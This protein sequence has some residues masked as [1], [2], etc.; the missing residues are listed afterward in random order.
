MNVETVNY[1]NISF[2]SWDVGGRSNVR[3]LW[4]H[5]FQNVNAMIY[6]LDSNDR[7]RISEAENEM[8]RIIQMFDDQSLQSIPILVYC[9]KQDLPNAMSV[10]EC[11]DKLGLH[12]LTVGHPWYIQAACF[13]SGDG[14]Y[15]GLE[16]LSN[17]LNNTSRSPALKEIEKQTQAKAQEKNNNATTIAVTT[18]AAPQQQISVATSETVVTA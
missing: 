3:P 9:N 5:Y 11:T 1:K 14:I 7:E 4:R 8:S 15:E 10:A 2:T 17:A 13:T 12:K 6:V 16:W 18:A